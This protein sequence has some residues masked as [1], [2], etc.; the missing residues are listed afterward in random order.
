MVS[1]EPMTT[2]NQI[3]KRIKNSPSPETKRTFFYVHETGCMKSGSLSGGEDEEGLFLICAVSGGNAE[4]VL[5]GRSY[6]LTKGDCF[7]IDCANSYTVNSEDEHTEVMWVCFGGATSAEYYDY[8]IADNRNVFRPSFIDKVVSA[9]NELIETNEKK[10]LN[11]EVISSKLI[12]DI[13]TIALTQSSD[14]SQNDS[15]LKQKLA[16]VNAFI[17]DHFNEAI[18]LEGLSSEFYISKYYLTREYKKIYGRTIF[19]QII[20][21]RIEY[22]K[23]LLRFSDKSVEEIAHLCGFNDQSYFA[24]Q[25]KKA[26]NITCFSYRKMWRE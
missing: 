10:L 18:T 23:K 25:F 11:A 20:A 1:N 12:M 9:V 2:H 7:F 6:P 19:Q 5:N 24:R 13:L 14:S 8:Y 17:D 22:G 16:A 21:A 4:L 15:A 3:S 26:E